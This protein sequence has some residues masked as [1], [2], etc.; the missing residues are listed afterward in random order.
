V[1]GGP[2]RPGRR[3][4]A[5]PPRR[6]PGAGGGAGLRAGQ[7]A[8]ELAGGGVALG[9]VAD[10]SA[11]KVF[12]SERTQRVGRLLEEVVGRH[13]DPADE[14]TAELVRWLD[15]QARRN[16][17]L[18]FGGGVNEVQRELVASIG[19]GLPRVPR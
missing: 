17:V 18:T 7:R 1:G 8:A 3:T 12:A 19:L 9:D 13:G 6:A 4:A 14:E 11:T 10:A 5:R 15:V 16:L 2:D